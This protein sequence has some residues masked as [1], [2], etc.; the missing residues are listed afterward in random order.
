MGLFRISLLKF[1]RNSFRMQSNILTTS[2]CQCVWYYFF[3]RRGITRGFHV[4]P[5][6]GHQARETPVKSTAFR[7]SFQGLPSHVTL[8]PKNFRRSFDFISCDLLVQCALKLH[9]CLKIVQKNRVDAFE[10]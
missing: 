5:E 9:Q 10:S 3:H 7:S 2:S 6:N 1:R 4:T 8:S